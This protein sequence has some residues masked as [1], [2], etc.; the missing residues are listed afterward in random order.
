MPPTIYMPRTDGGT[1]PPAKDRLIHADEVA[2][3]YGIHPKTALRL[4]KEGKIPAPLEKTPFVKRPCWLES[5]ID[6]HLESL[7]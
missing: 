6:K 7:K 2:R 1:Q 3:R 4:A 5:V